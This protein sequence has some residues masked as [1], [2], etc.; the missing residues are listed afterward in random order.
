VGALQF[1]VALFEQGPEPR[2]SREELLAMAIELGARLQLGAPV[3]Q[4]V[5]EV[6]LLRVAVD[7]Y[8]NGDF[9]RIWYVTDGRNILLVTYVCKWESRLIEINECDALVASVQFD[10]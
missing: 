1:S 7:Y 10:S 4:S 6:P 5:D 9:F 3:A 8:T 2:S